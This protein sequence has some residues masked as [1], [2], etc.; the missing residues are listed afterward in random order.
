VIAGPEGAKNPAGESPPPDSD[1]F[2]GV[3][4][5]KNLASLSSQFAARANSRFE[6]QKR[7]QLF[8]RSHNETFSVVAVCDGQQKDCPNLCLH[9]NYSLSY[10]RAESISADY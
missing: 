6:F 9:K 1:P 2:D 3:E 7:S 5:G 8:I 4:S 10:H